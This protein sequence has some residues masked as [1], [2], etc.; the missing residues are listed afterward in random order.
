MELSVLTE[1]ML[2]GSSPP[3]KSSDG[4]SPVLKMVF[5][6]DTGLSQGRLLGLLEGW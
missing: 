1:H 3:G 5:A 2:S 4:Q 6:M